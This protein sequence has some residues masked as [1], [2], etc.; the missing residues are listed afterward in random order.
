M[1]IEY[2]GLAEKVSGGY[3]VFFPD[4]PGCGSAGG[5]LEETRKNAREGLI[6]HIELMLEEKETIPKSS[7]LDEVMKLK[8]A[9]SCIPLVIGIVA[10]SGKAQRVNITLDGELLNAID[11][12]AANQHKTRSAL[13]AEAAQRLIGAL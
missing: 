10:P 5:S 11:M 13:L 6:A 8:E 9:K 3:S 4:F 2:I 7:S 12:M 1:I